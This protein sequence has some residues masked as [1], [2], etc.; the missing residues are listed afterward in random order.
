MFHIG[1]CVVYPMHGAGIIESIEEKEVLGSSKKY[2]ILNL[3]Q[4]EIKIMLPMEKAKD[5]GL[6]K[7]ISK[8]QLPDVYSIINGNGDPEQLQNNWNRR[9]MLNL[10][11]LKS[12]D[13]F[14]V[15]G[16]FRTLREREEEK[17]LSTGEK[18]MLEDVKKIISSEL[19]LVEGSELNLLSSYLDSRG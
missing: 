9:Y 1:E 6:R 11:K 17:G 8:E 12:G 3:A 5:L 4:G 7:I 2:Y 19:A 18:K 14:E 10:E 16:V 13:I 15:A